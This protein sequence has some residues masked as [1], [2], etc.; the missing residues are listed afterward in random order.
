LVTG[1]HFHAVRASTHSSIILSTTASLPRF[2]LQPST[3]V[4]SCSTTL[5]F[6]MPSYTPNYPSTDYHPRPESRFHPRP[7]SPL[8]PQIA[9]SS[10]RQHRQSP[11]SFEVNTGTVLCDDR[12]LSAR[13]R[14]LVLLVT[15]YPK[16]FV[17]F[18]TDLRGLKRHRKDFTEEDQNLILKLKNWPLD[19]ERLKEETIE[20]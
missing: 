8:R 9:P 3:K 15:R 12:P 19:S 17:D 7:R 14:T 10:P 13:Q 2:T 18:D 4:R 1:F 6:H 16:Q 11:W 5:F 20:G